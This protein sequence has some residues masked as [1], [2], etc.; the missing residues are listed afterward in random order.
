MRQAVRNEQHGT[1]PA[2]FAVA[3]PNNVIIHRPKRKYCRAD[4]HF[5][6]DKQH[7]FRDCVTCDALTGQSKQSRNSPF[8]Y[9]T[10]TKALRALIS[11]KPAAFRHMTST[12]GTTRY[13]RND[14]MSDFSPKIMSCLNFFCTEV[15][16]IIKSTFRK[17]QRIS[18]LKHEAAQALAC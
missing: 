7:L 5:D 16:H 6:A 15:C 3:R 13:I 2:R 17:I 18:T 11:C 9:R 12:S 10:K 8:I 4:S 1:S 14:S